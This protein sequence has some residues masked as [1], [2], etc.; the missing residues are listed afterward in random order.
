M[1]LRPDQCPNCTP[2]LGSHKT[3]FKLLE[4]PEV[5]RMARYTEEELVKQRVK[6]L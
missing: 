6:Q 4:R 2:T 1:P 5:T 3:P